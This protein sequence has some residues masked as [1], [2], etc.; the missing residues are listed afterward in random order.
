VH[1][2][3]DSLVGEVAAVLVQALVFQDV[4]VGR[5][6]DVLLVLVSALVVISVTQLVVWDVILPAQIWV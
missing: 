6:V 5:K 1:D 2:N 3:V 4:L